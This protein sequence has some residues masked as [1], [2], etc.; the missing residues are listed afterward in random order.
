MPYWVSQTK[1]PVA[2]KIAWVKMAYSAGE[3]SARE[4]YRTFAKLYE[5]VRGQQHSLSV[6]AADG[7]EG[8]YIHLYFPMYANLWFEGT[9]AECETRA[10]RLN[11]LH[12]GREVYSVQYEY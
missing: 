10:A 2:E 6:E 8:Y 12:P 11:R 7:R 1:G 3:L 5:D 4:A 9:H